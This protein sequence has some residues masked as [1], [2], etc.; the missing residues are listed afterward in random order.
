[1]AFVRC[2]AINIYAFFVC[3][4]RNLVS[5]LYAACAD[6]RVFASAPA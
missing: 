4:G 2:F 1:M 5:Q 6:A 3:H